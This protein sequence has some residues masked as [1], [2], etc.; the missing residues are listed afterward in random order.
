L[1]IIT[2]GKLNDLDHCE[3]RHGIEDLAMAVREAQATPCS[4]SR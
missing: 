4:A 3:G 2:D 1:L